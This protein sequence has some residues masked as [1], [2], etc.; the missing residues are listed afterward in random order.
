MDSV[1]L[2]C[3]L[4]GPERPRWRLRS[5]PVAWPRY[6][7]P[8]IFM[9]STPTIRVSRHRL[10]PRSFG[11]LTPRDLHVLTILAT[12]YVL[13][14]SQIRRLCFPSDDGRVTRRRLSVLRADG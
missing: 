5:Q 3:E 12:Y 11:M 9:P 2:A 1:T 13:R 8:G 6:P 10:F 4:T 7:T 14:A